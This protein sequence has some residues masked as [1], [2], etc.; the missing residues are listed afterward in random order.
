MF[1]IPVELWSILSNPIEKSNCQTRDRSWKGRRLGPPRWS[2]RGEDH[3]K[4]ESGDRRLATAARA[5][6]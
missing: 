4:S 5:G 1:H 3:L 2:L 6:G